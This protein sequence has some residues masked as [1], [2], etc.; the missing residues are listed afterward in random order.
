MVRFVLAYVALVFLLVASSGCGT[1]SP[2]GA[3]TTPPVAAP[4]SPT[5]TAPAVAIPRAVKYV[6][7]FTSQEGKPEA[8]A[9]A[10]LVDEKQYAIP[11]LH[12]KDWCLGDGKPQPE[13][14]EVQLPVHWDLWNPCDMRVPASFAP[15]GTGTR[16]TMVGKIRYEGRYYISTEQPAK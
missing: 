9:V 12:A 8:D 5:A 13:S 14:S 10:L 15:S 3:T 4:A 6:V 7:I 1:V 2:A 11:Q 16:E